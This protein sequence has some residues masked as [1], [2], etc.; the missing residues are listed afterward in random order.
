MEHVQFRTVVSVWHIYIRLFFS[1]FNDCV[2]SNALDSRRLLFITFE[3]VGGVDSLHYDHYM[4]TTLLYR[5]SSDII[6]D[7]LRDT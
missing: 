6:T 7:T 2:S 4:I 5:M 3:L 1:N